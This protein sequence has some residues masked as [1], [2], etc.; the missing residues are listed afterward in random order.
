MNRIKRKVG[1][2]LSGGGAKGAYEAGALCS[3]VKKIPQIHVVT[4]A[5]IGAINGAV[6]ALE[7][8]KTGDIVGAAET[9]KSLWSDL[10][11][12]FRISPWHIVLNMF[13]SYFKTRSP[14][15]FPALI[16]S[17]GIENKLE[18]LIPRNIRISDL[19]R[20]E[21]AINATCLTSGQTV[22]F[23][24]E[25]D[26]FLY[27]AV[28]ASSS[29]PIAFASRFMNGAYYVDGGCLITLLFV[30]LSGPSD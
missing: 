21:L 1:V 19:S 23:T 2:V 25:N 20:I 10:G 18:E 5:S 3:I 4:G 28:L 17:T 16:D 14:L 6:F 29:I 30:M 13:V 15:R 27:D 26:V 24:R 8:E 11:S 7:Y 22:S 12:L 9:V